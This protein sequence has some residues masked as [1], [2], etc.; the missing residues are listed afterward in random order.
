MTENIFDF[1]QKNFFL[2]V[3]KKKL[4]DIWLTKWENLLEIIVFR[5]TFAHVWLDLEIS[6]INNPPYIEYS[7]NFLSLL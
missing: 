4:S 2:Q 5:Q 7:L 6:V 1:F 3:F